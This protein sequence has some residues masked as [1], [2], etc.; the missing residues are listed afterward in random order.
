LA[1]V[2]QPHEVGCWSGCVVDE[3]ARASRAFYTSVRIRDLDVGSIAMARC[4]GSG[5]LTSGP[6]DVGV[7]GP[8][9]GI[10]ITTFRDPYVW[11]DREGWTMI[12]G[13]GAADGTG[14]VLRYRSRDLDRWQYTGV[15]CSGRAATDHDLT[16]GVWE[17]PQMVEIDDVWVLVVSVGV[18][19]HAG[20]VL[21]AAGSYDGYHF[22]SE[23]WRRLA[24]GTA[25][26]ATSVF[27]DR[28]GRPCMISWLQED[29]RHD[30]GS[31]GWAGAESLVSELAVDR[32]GRV[33]AA[34]HPG[35]AS[36]GMF[37]NHPPVAG[38]SVHSLE[39]STSELAT[40]LTAEADVPVELEVRRAGQRLV[41]I[42][43]S[44]GDHRV[45]VDR[46]GH[47][48]DVLPCQKPSGTIELFIDA[49]ILEIFGGGYYGASRLTSTSPSPNA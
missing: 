23:D 17:C 1:L 15:L 30:A 38:R 46:P 7:A 12:V 33:T 48:I 3:A 31:S 29:P 16:R 26:Y 27:R 20:H 39:E 6:G 47:K 25:P 24:F 41:Y 42:T 45:V 2:P 4:D 22:V 13:G 9:D 32:T 14:A 44:R 5:R 11:R 49:D 35:L 28:D 21:A 8:P 34:P 37:A 40:H 19:G 18:E 43:R 10:R 36:S